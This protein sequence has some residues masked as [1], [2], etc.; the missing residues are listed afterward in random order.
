MEEAEALCDRIAI[1]V[2]GQLRCLG[3]PTH[4][5]KKYGSGYQL[6]IIYATRA[7][8]ITALNVTSFLQSQL[9]TDTILL[10]SH[11][12][13]LLYQLP[14]VC[15]S[16]SDGQNGTSLTLGQV[17]VTLQNGMKTL[18]IT[19]YSLSRPSLEQVFLRFAREQEHPE[20]TA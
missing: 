10:E 11:G 16:M 6:E 7:E 13:R 1:Q 9:S 18:G 3:A 5:K 8:D 14:P 2:K 19:D 4:I 15:N 20:A 17:F 12:G